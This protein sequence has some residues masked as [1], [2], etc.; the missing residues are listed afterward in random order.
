MKARCKRRFGDDNGSV[1]VEALLVVPVFT[2]FAIGVLEFGNVLWQ[3]NQL[4][5]G[6]RDAARYWSRCRPNPAG[7][8]P[9]GACSLETARNIAFYGSP[10]GGGDPRIPNWT[11]D[12]QLSIL[13][14]A[15]DL[16]GVPAPEDLVIVTGE[17]VY[18]GSPVFRTLMIPDITI[19]YKHTERYIGW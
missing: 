14:A 10:D 13:P 17:L 4:Q 16:P 8:W 18:D 7:S 3:R 15:D 9:G 11:E 6:V 19:E 2:L 5:T 12:S 1:L